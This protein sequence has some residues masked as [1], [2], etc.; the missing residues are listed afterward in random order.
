MGRRFT[1][2][3]PS[4][5]LFSDAIFGIASDAVNNMHDSSYT[6][7]IF[8]QPVLSDHHFQKFSTLV[9]RISGINLTVAKKAM[10]S[11]RLSKRLRFLGLNSFKEYL[12]YLENKDNEQQEIVHLL[13]VVST[14][15]TEF[16]REDSHFHYLVQQCLPDI[17]TRRVHSGQPLRVWSA[18]CSSGQEP[19]TIAM[20]LADYA[21]KYGNFDFS[22]LATDICTRVLGTAEKAIYS[23]ELTEGI[24]ASYK[25]KYFM[26]GKGSQKGMHRVV[27]EIRNK[28]RFR[29]LN[30]NDRKFGIKTPMDIIFC[31]N[32]IIYFDKSTQEV[33]FEKFYQ[34]LAGKG[35]LFI[36]H[37][38]SLS[39]IMDRMQRMAPAV[40]RRFL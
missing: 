22:I 23:D 36:G 20:V 33:L 6:P 30:F 29:R 26:R 21:E 31:R 38:E 35:Y 14:N 1:S 10:L 16:F 27:P 25:F 9:Y 37:S 17:L 40:Y 8:E 11:S 12:Q 2:A 32:V 24:P 34:Q 7:R 15:K 13:D 28:I 18:G 19:Y 5:K 3:R 4:M 39:G